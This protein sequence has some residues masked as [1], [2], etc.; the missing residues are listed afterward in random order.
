LFLI[1]KNFFCT[2]TFL[3]IVW[4][5][6][7]IFMIFFIFKGFFHGIKFL[8]ANELI[9][10]INRNKNIIIVDTRNDELFSKGHIIHAINMSRS[11]IKLNKNLVKL[12][13]YKNFLIVIVFQNDYEIDIGYLNYLKSIGYKRI[14]VLKNG[15]SGWLSDNYPI[16]KSK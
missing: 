13:K 15:I 2:H 8:P 5:T 12:N 9:Y 1:L 14:C 6:S 7:F 16:V 4:I 10:L 3:S 11:A